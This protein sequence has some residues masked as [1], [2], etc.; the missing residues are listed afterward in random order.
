VD[1]IAK[2]NN[3]LVIVDHETTEAQRDRAAVDDPDDT[4]REL[5]LFVRVVQVEVNTAVSEVIHE[6]VA[7]SFD[8]VREVETRG[9]DSDRMRDNGTSQDKQP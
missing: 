3:P 1:L 9:R 4:L 2:G 7:C 8:T 6:L 5:G